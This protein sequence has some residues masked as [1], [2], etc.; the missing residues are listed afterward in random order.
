MRL[1]VKNLPLHLGSILGRELPSADCVPGSKKSKSL[2]N[3]TGGRSD[4]HSNGDHDLI[5]CP[6]V[7]LNF[8]VTL[9][10]NPTN[11]TQMLRSWN[12]DVIESHEAIVLGVIA[13]FGAEIADLNSRE[14]FMVV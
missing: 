9:L 10:V 4:L 12:S 8:E 6:Q 2:I 1:V 11:P 5:D 7:P 14:T 3:E 13:K